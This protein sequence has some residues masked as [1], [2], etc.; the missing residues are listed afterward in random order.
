MYNIIIIIMII[1]I[2]IIIIII[3]YYSNNNKNTIVIIVIVFFKYIIDILTLELRQS[4]ALGDTSVHS[5]GEDNDRLWPQ[6]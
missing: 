2:V 5:Q 6:Q 1:I 3:I 4:L